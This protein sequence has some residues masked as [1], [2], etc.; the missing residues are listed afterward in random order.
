MDYDPVVE[1][2]AFEPVVAVVE[3]LAPGVEIVRPGVAA[4]AVRGP[5]R[6]FGGEEVFA[7]RL[8]DHL[9]VAGYPAAVGIADGPFAAE[10]AARARTVFPPGASAACL[11]PLPIE[12]LER[13]E[14]TDLL[15]RLGIRTLGAF[16]QLPAARVLERFGH[17]GALA[18][19]L[20]SGQEDRPLATRRPPSDLT[21]ELVLE[22]PVDRVDQVTF[23]VR[24]TAE[25]LAA[26]LSRRDL[27]CTSLSLE[28]TWDDGAVSEREWRHPRWFSAADLVDRV[29]WQ[30]QASSV[31]ASTNTGADTGT[32]ASAGADG[33][34]G[35]VRV[36]LRPAEVDR[37]GTFATGLWDEAGPSEHVHR[38]AGRVQSMLG[39][40]GVTTAVVVGG[41]AP[42]D[43]VRYVPWGDAPDVVGGSGRSG[44]LAAD[45][46][47]GSTAGRSAAGSGGGS[48]C[49][50]GAGAPAYPGSVPP[51]RPSRVFAE[52]RP[53]DPSTLDV[54]GWAGPWPVQERWWDAERSREYERYQVTCAD[55]SAY[56][57]LR[58]HDRWYLEAS[59][60]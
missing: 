40:E 35:V 56:L 50:D 11:A 54:V 42:A 22:P 6:Y 15:R 19:R 9:E 5:S 21:T 38:A 12:T 51:P 1:A 28:V 24:E 10:Q 53:I 48:G 58:E 14:L 4:V 39:H 3:E 30:L 2:R 55:S 41:R 44:G 25:E 27:V 46:S 18:H 49:A 43:R 45:R 17:D 33:R 37:T 59:Y 36:R 47:G 57:L 8:L 52:P 31:G 60:D 29:R 34:G 20:A 32:A 23:A 7:E 26:D 13:P 16:A